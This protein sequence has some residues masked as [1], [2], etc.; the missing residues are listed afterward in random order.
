M[1]CKAH[2]RLSKP[3]VTSSEGMRALL[4]GFP[5]GDMLMAEQSG[6]NADWVLRRPIAIRGACHVVVFL[7]RAF[8]DFSAC[9][10]A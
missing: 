2:P 6:R 7:S 10:I 5:A 8:A 3:S 4:D 9:A 1:N